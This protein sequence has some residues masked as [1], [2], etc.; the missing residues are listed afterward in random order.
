VLEARGKKLRLYHEMIRS[1]D[2]ELLATCNQ[3]LL[4]VSL[5][6]RRTCEPEGEVLEKITALGKAQSK[7]PKPASMRD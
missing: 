5:E 3:L 4:H 1:A 2:D 7:L 6:T